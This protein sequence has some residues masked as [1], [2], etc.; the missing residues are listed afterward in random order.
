MAVQYV[1]TKRITCDK[2]GTEIAV[3]GKVQVLAL[4]EITGRSTIEMVY[5]LCALHQTEVQK[6]LSDYINQENVMRNIQDR[7]T[8]KW[9]GES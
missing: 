2:C 3:R 8:V 9:L 6:L 5:D 1:S 7:S 4:P